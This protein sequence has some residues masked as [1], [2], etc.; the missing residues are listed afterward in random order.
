MLSRAL[1]YRS[2]EFAPTVH[3]STEQ[4]PEDGKRSSRELESFSQNV[5]STTAVMVSA[6]YIVMRAH[7]CVF[8]G[9]G[10]V[11]VRVRALYWVICGS[12][13]DPDKIQFIYTSFSAKMR[14]EERH[15]DVYS[16]P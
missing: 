4:V 16:W 12:F 2:L 6:F 14:R 13:P 11:L 8:L 1:P 10:L 9:V 7:S 3:L 15:L 5:L